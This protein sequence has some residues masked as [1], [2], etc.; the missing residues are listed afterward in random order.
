MYPGGDVV[1]GTENG[2]LLLRSFLKVS[3][4]KLSW[5]PPLFLHIRNALGDLSLRIDAWAVGPAWSMPT[6][7]GLALMLR[8]QQPREMDL[9]FQGRGYW[10][11]WDSVLLKNC[12]EAQGL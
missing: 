2:G 9:F 4:R 3:P 10:W 6:F 11:E 1:Y 12:L 5:G 7:S 8:L